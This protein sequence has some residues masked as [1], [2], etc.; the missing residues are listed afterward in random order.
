MS[1]PLAAS[2]PFGNM[3]NSKR[4]MSALAPNELE[5]I[6]LMLPPTFELF[7]QLES[8]LHS[9]LDGRPRV[10]KVTERDTEEKAVMVAKLF[11]DDQ[12]VSSGQ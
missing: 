6:Q 8:V 9:L 4:R 10:I 2:S 7:F 3:T 11:F 5:S 12:E 1:N